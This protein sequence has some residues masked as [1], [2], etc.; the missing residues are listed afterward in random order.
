ML[1]KG[2]QK[3]RIN[4]I[5]NLRTIWICCLERMEYDKVKTTDQNNR[6]VLQIEP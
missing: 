5:M 4:C 3:E 1:E 2:S 6:F